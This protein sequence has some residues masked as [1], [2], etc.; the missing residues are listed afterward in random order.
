VIESFS[1][2][3][4]T[5]NEI[6]SGKKS[7]PHN[8]PTGRKDLAQI[9]IDL[10]RRHHECHCSFPTLADQVGHWPAWRKLTH[11]SNQLQKRKRPVFGTSE[12]ASSPA[13]ASEGEEKTASASGYRF[14]SRTTRR[15]Y[16]YEATGFATPHRQSCTAKSKISS[17]VLFFRWSTKMR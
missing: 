8:S 3:S 11:K 16:C 9:R 6:L 17:L 5:I 10:D 2:A 12:S 1:I 14:Q 15:K 13:V 7:S 4:G